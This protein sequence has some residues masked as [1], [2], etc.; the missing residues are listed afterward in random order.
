MIPPVAQPKTTTDP[1]IKTVVATTDSIQ[2]IR[3]EEQANKTKKL[4]SDLSLKR[5]SRPRKQIMI[6]NTSK[7]LPKLNLNMD[8]NQL[9]SQLNISPQS[10][11]SV[12]D[13]SAQNIVFSGK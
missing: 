9:S 13:N 10:S 3:S 4:M 7:Q 5:R 11:N 6:V 1:I 8:L 2:Q 12:N